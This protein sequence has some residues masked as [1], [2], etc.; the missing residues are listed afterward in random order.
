MDFGLYS[1]LM[2]Q[3]IKGSGGIISFM[4]RECSHII[5]RNRMKGCFSMEKH[6][7]MGSISIEPIVRV[8]SMLAIGNKT[9]NKDSALKSLEMAA[10]TKASTTMESVQAKVNALSKAQTNT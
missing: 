6:K 1:G 9:K 3:L 4:D 5:V 10:C 7:G 2:G 8:K